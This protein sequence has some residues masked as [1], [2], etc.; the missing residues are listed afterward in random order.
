MQL[1]LF[2]EDHSPLMP[3]P[4]VHHGIQANSLPSLRLASP[5]VCPDWAVSNGT[6]YHVRKKTSCIGAPAEIDC[7]KKTVYCNKLHLTR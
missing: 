7:T 1:S 6:H 4:P 5:L 3:M 2:A